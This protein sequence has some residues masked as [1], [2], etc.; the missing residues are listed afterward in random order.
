MRGDGETVNGR[1]LYR[2]IYG[3]LLLA[4]LVAALALLPHGEARAQRDEASPVRVVNLPEVQR[5]GG[6]VSLERPVRLAELVTLPEVVAVPA[7]RGDTAELVP[8]GS[9]ETDGYGTVVLS[10]A[11]EVR[12]RGSAGRVG[13]LLVPATE[14]VGEA[15]RQGRILFP[16]EVSAPVEA[17]EPW[18]ESA[19]S[20]ATVA[21]PR[22]R[23]YLYNT[24]DRSVAVRL[25]AYLTAG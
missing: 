4:L 20:R 16:L 13:A 6:S 25:Y 7:D 3:L 5:V 2:A 22:Y 9:L 17:G 11:G 19:A 24:T 15:F 10:L 1:R 14:T 12:G 18:V 8:A 21:F 23:V